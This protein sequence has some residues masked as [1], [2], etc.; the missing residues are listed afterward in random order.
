MT[1]T[2][3][4]PPHQEQPDPAYQLQRDVYL[5]LVFDLRRELPPPDQDTP[6]GWAHRDRL[7]IAQ[8]AAMV[9]ANSSEAHLAADA[10]RAGAYAGRCYREL[11]E[12]TA[13]PR[14]AAQLIAQAASFGRESRGF[15]SLLLRAQ[16]HRMKREAND[17]T[18]DAAFWTEHSAHG[19]MT[20]ALNRLPPPIRPA[21]PAPTAQ[22]AAPATPPPAPTPQAAAE[23][24]PP[25]AAAAPRPL[26][27][28]LRPRLP[29]KY[30]PPPPGSEDEDTDGKW[31]V[32]DFADD[33]DSDDDLDEAAD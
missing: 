30:P 12:G 14:R 31:P 22:A 23:A 5:Q 2:P 3:P 6:S 28:T 32:D 9:P 19:L 17:A 27:T 4:P 25:P 16:T 21:P 20:D 29:V 11:A 7:A 8:A 33:R 26:I 24:A 18:R 10:V 1:D 13:D 15:H